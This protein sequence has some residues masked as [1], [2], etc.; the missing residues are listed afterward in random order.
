MSFTKYIVPALDHHI[1]IDH[2]VAKLQLLK[3]QF[4]LSQR[5]VAFKWIPGKSN[6]LFILSGG[7]NKSKWIPGKSNLLFILS[8][9]K[10]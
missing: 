2:I 1:S 9:G 6:L 7:K 5:D 4:T 8:G 3:V 10:N